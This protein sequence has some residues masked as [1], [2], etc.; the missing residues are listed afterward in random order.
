MNRL[1]RLMLFVFVAIV[2][3]TGVGAYATK[4]PLFDENRLTNHT[5]LYNS[6]VN[7]FNR[8]ITAFSPNAAGQNKN[9]WCWAAASKLVGVH[10]DVSGLPT[11]A[12]VLTDVGGLHSWNSTPFYGMNG[13]G[14]YTADAGQRGIVYAIKGSDEDLCGN[15]TER[16]TAL[17]L[18]SLN[19][20]TVGTWGNGTLSSTD[21]AN[22]NYEL[23][24]GRW[25]IANVYPTS[26]PNL[27]GH[28]VVLT[29][30][31]LSTQVY[32]FWDP[33]TNT[34]GSFTKNNIL[35]NTIIVLCDS[36]ARTL[37]WVQYCK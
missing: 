13:A 24:H 22:M 15:N 21:I 9:N 26:N 29:S 20:M 18:A 4:A 23:T 7:Q 35:N 14:Q 2:L 32:S 37:K 12:A 17:Q 25:V 6:T 10:N 36:V 28:S 19:T 3:A 1:K 5:E 11:G 16:E 30:V 31:N 34:T 8:A 33:W 27:I